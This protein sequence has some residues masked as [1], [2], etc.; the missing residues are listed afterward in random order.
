MSDQ[1]ALPTVD[2]VETFVVSLRQRAMPLNTIKSYAHDLRL[3]VQAVPADLAIVT[4]SVQAMRS[5]A[6][7]CPVWMLNTSNG[8][9]LI[10]YTPFK[11]GRSADMHPCP[12]QCLLE[13]AVAMFAAE[14]RRR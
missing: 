10:G 7:S 12:E 4:S 11:L 6:N 9:W 5:L 3:F 14:K 1:P 2:A 8:A 13:K